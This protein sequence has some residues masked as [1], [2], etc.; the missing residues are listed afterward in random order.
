MRKRTRL[1]VA[2]SSVTWENLEEYRNDYG[3]LRK[4]SMQGGTITV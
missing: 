2:G 4:L 3:K 1:G